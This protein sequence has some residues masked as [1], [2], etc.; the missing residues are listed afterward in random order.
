MSGGI[1]T[2]LGQVALLGL[3]FGSIV[4]LARLLEPSDFGLV[5]MV[6]A[7]VGFLRIFNDAGLSTATV[8]KEGITHAQVS[9]LF[10]TNVALGVFISLLLAISAPVVAWLY[11]EPRLVRIT[12]ALSVTF[13]LTS[14]TVQHLALLKRQMRFRTL[15]V[16][17]V[18]AAVFGVVVGVG[19]AW[20]NCGY[21]SLVGTQLTPPLM[22]CVCT[23]W[24]SCWR[25][26]LPVRGSGTRSLLRFGANL[27]ASSFLWSLARGSD[28]VLIGR[29]FGSEALGFYSR[30]AALLNRPLEQA[31]L[32]LESVFVPLLSRLQA[33]P[34]RYRRTVLQ[35]YDIIAVGS[36]PFSGMLLALSNPVTLVV[37]GPRWESAAAVFA[38]FTLVGL[39]L[40]MVSVAGWVLSSQGRGR[41]YLLLSCFTSATTVM[42]FIIGLR[43]GPVGVAFSFSLSCLLIQLPVTYWLA[44]GPL[45]STKDF[46][47]RFLRHVPL[48]AAVSGATWLAKLAVGD[49]APLTQLYLSAPAG[50]VMTA[51]FMAL[52]PP[53][54]A[55]AVDIIGFAREWR[56][57]HRASSAQQCR[58]AKAAL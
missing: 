51:A 27:T 41:D 50:L 43:F 23:W 57:S 31:L 45:V 19:M 30:A 55:A 21:W 4:V 29:F 14:S 35:V 34:E 24:A 18:A 15:A 1:V 36:L 8:Q 58:V 39:Y 7:I 38:A 12:V 10:W 28:G 40:P 56:R 52:Y 6:S 44:G 25:P 3:N 46:W 22:T 26:Q 48:W 54:R 13:F 37:L 42:S 9:N 32:P 33:Q 2:G 11:R 49:A 17:Q 20:F 53:S 5:A 47:R 16:I